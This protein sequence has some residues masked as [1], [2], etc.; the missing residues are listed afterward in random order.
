[1]SVQVKEK[2]YCLNYKYKSKFSWWNVKEEGKISLTLNKIIVYVVYNTI[3]I[4][5][6]WKVKRLL[7][8]QLK[9]SMFENIVWLMT[10]TMLCKNCE[11]LLYLERPKQ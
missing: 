2:V 7:S 5:Y 6:D 11:S 10:D 9:D 1:M 8:C 3:F 4:Q